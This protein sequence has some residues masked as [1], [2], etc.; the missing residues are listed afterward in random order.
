MGG[1]YYVRKILTMVLNVLIEDNSK[2]KV[3]IV[4]LLS[5]LVGNG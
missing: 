2:V 5:L 1:Q 3:L 4:L